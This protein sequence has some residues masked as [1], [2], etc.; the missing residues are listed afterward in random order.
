MSSF[1]TKLITNSAIALLL[2]GYTIHLWRLSKNKTAREAKLKRYTHEPKARA[3]YDKIFSLEFV[4]VVALLAASSLC[5]VIESAVG[6]A[7]GRVPAGLQLVIFL[8][9]LIT[10][11]V[12]VY[13]AVRLFKVKK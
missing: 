3:L 12:A 13:M 2:V 1:T 10:L 7:I 11:F 6:M 8:V 5:S 4:K 9:G